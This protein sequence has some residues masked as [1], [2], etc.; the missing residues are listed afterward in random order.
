MIH[1]KSNNRCHRPYMFVFTFTLWKL[2]PP[3]RCSF[4]FGFPFS[5]L[6]LHSGLLLSAQLSLLYTFAF[7]VHL[8]YFILCPPMLIFPIPR[9]LRPLCSTFNSHAYTQSLHYHLLFILCLVIR[10]HCYIF[11]FTWELNAEEYP[12][13]SFHL[14]SVCVEQLKLMR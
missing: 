2:G 6:S 12:F 7:S 14:V 4:M 5:L 1:F 3:S 8:I 9:H 13:F 11:T 10:A